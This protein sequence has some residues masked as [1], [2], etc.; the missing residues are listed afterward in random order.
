[1]KSPG[2]DDYTGEYYEIVKEKLTPILY[3]LFKKIEEEKAL[4]N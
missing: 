3:N 1:M 4:S 2:P